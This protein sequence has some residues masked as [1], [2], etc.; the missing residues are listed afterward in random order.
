MRT[1]GLTV[2]SLIVSGFVA[3]ATAGMSPIVEIWQGADDSAAMQVSVVDGDALGKGP[4]AFYDY[5]S[6]SAH[7]GF[8]QANTSIAFVYEYAGQM[9]LFLIHHIEQNGRGEITQNITGLPTGWAHLVKDDQGNGGLNDTYTTGANSL[10][11][12]WA[13]SANTD[14]SALGLG[15]NA[16]LVGE[17]ITVENQRISGI[18]S[19][20][21]LGDGGVTEM[22]LDPQQTLNIR[23]AVPE[24]TSVLSGLGGIA[25]LLLL[26]RRG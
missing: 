3:S 11:A 8:E 26:R 20:L 19:W 25:S 17:V 5:R 4:V 15:A 22:Q 14:G 24:P 13:W 6:A 16:D 9:S 21:F 10:L 1:F 23:F 18:Q 7:T 2:A 12:E